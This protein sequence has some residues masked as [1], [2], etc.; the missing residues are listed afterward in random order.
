MAVSH[1]TPSVVPYKLFRT[2]FCCSCRWDDSIYIPELMPPTGL[3]LIP[4]MS[5]ESHG[6][7]ISAGVNSLIRP[8]EVSSKP[9]SSHL[10]A[11]Q[12]ELAK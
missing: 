12:D 5:M 4:Q 6:G 8:P 10:V 1:S 11:K 9:T 7:M 2:C 3:L